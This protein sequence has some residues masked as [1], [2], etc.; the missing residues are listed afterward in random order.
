[1]N[2]KRMVKIIKSKLKSFSILVVNAPT[3]GTCGR[4]MTHVLSRVCEGVFMAIC[5]H[6]IKVCTLFKATPDCPNHS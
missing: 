1:M 6:S 4:R 5:K 2:K 3:Q